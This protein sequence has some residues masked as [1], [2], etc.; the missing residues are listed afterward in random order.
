[1]KLFHISDIL[2]ATT[3]RL[4]SYRHMDGVYAIYNFLTGDNLYTHQLIRAEE[5]C[6]QWLQ[7]QYPQ[8]MMDAPGMADR[9]HKLDAALQESKQ[10]DEDLAVV[11]VKWVEEVREELGLPEMLP[12]HELGE[13]MHT[14]IDPLEELQVMVGSKKK[15]IVV[16]N[17]TDADSASE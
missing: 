8:L 15:V 12:V 10:T 11:V 17:D 3:R 14:H 2:S 16:G 1:M 6:A 7:A 5:E 9:L 4:V 13:D